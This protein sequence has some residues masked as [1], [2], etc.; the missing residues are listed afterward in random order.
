MKKILCLAQVALVVSMGC[1]QEKQANETR[2]SMNPQGIT[3]DLDNF[4][5]FQFYS[6]NGTDE[7]I[8]AR[9]TFEVKLWFKENVERQLSY[10]QN[11]KN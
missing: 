6:A 7:I 10:P 8:G 9:E 1:N 2:V 4:I 5:H 3:N 11:C